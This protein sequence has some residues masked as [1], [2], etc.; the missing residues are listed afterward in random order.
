MLPMYLES[1]FAKVE[2]NEVAAVERKKTTQFTWQG[3]PPRTSWMPRYWSHGWATF[4]GD[5]GATVALDGVGLGAGR[6]GSSPA[7]GV[8]KI[9]FRRKDCPDY[10]RQIAVARGP[11]GGTYGV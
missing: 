10:A 7:V 9:F 11:N 1:D 4:P 2:K 6:R 8:E 5:L 3:N